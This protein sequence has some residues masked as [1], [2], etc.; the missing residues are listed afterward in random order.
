MEEVSYGRLVCDGSIAG[1]GLLTEPVI[2]DIKDGM[3]TNIQGGEQAERFNAMLSKVGGKA[4]AV[5]EFGIGTNPKAEICGMILEDEKVM[6]TVHIA[7]GN[8]IS[9]E[10]SIDVPIHIDCIIKSPS[11]IADGKPI[12]ENGKFVF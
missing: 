5:A 2:I 9:M 4:K 6:G 12:M 3:I 11:F 7:F 1:I 10:G 8:N